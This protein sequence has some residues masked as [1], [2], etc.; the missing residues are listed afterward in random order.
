M[1]VLLEIPRNQKIEM[2]KEDGFDCWEGDMLSHVKP[3][4][5]KWQ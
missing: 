3:I 4:K 1:H 5:R 2:S